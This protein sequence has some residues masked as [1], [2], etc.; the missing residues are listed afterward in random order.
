MCEVNAI[1]QIKRFIFLAM[2]SFVTMPAV[3]NELQGL[4]ISQD[5]NGKPTGYINIIKEDNIYRGEIEKGLDSDKEETCCTACKD[6]RKD[7]RLIGMTVLK[8]VI[9]KSE[10]SYEVQKF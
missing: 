8:N 3:A 2:V 9:K 4:W 6:E 1:K 5:D 7:K 10:G